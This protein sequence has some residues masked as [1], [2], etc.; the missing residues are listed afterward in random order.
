M[1]KNSEYKF[2]ARDVVGKT[3][4][5]VYVEHPSRSSNPIVQPRRALAGQIR[6]WPDGRY[7]ASRLRMAGKQLQ[8]VGLQGFFWSRE[9]A[10]DA[11]RVR[12]DPRES[13]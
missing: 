9:Q 5:I 13:L 7:S 1:E 11:I 3:T 8:G 6:R 4:S 10:I 2:D 12:F